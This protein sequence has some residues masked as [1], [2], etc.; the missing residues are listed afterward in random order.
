MWGWY[1]CFV[2]YAVQHHTG[3]LNYLVPRLGR[4]VGRNICRLFA[5]NKAG[6]FQGGNFVFALL[7]EWFWEDCSFLTSEPQ[8]WNSR[9]ILTYYGKGTLADSRGLWPQ[10]SRSIAGSQTRTKWTPRLVPDANCIWSG[11]SCTDP[12]NIVKEVEPWLRAATPDMIIKTEGSGRFFHSW[13]VENQNWRLYFWSA[14]VL[15]DKSRS[16]LVGID[17][18][19]S[20][21]HSHSYIFG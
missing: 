11:H 17:F 13:K 18:T 4:V 7:S 14:K 20:T 6:I 10:T 8:A 16:F 3:I 1:N 5:G 12:S 15:I 2:P 21:N 19:K 9:N